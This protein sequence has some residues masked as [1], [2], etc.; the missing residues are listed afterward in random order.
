M[1]LFTK[2]DEE[3]QTLGASKAAGAALRRWASEHGALQGFNSVRELV[4]FVQHSDDRARG[5]AIAAALARLARSDAF[6]ARTFLQVVLYGLIR[7]AADFRTA[8][9]SDEDAASTTIAFAYERI[10]TYPIDRRPRSV[11]ANV[12]LDTRQ[13]VSRSLCK[14]RV[15]EVLTADVRRATSGDS[16]E[17]ATNELL[18]LLDEAV[19][20][21]RLRIEDAQLIALT[22]VADVPTSHLAEVRGARPQSLRRR[23]LRAEAALA[24]AVA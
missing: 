23:R 16:E 22:R 4:Q 10:R 14:R 5:N 11:I 7:I 21:R 15:T 8:T 13:A 2:L 17:S 9:H 18:S 24:A 6:A 1:K 3:W 20:M 19:R 12:L